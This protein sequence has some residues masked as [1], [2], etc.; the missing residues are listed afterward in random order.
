LTLR[1]TAFGLTV[2]VRDYRPDRVPE[3]PPVDPEPPQRLSGLFIVAALT[4][5]WGIM[6][7]TDAKTV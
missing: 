3:P 2:E 6:P 5:E 1:Y 4:R 7:R